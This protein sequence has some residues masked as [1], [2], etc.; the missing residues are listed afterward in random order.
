MIRTARRGGAGQ[1]VPDLGGIGPGGRWVSHRPRGR[2][3]R[4]DADAVASSTREMAE[5][6][7]DCG[8]AAPVPGRGASTGHPRR[9]LSQRRPALPRLAN[10]LKKRNQLSRESAED[11]CRAPKPEQ[12][13]VSCRQLQAN[14]RLLKGL[15]ASMEPSK[16]EALR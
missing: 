14:K 12:A 5:G 8:R 15:L 10:P 6:G 1:A 16:R 4:P 11:R 9:T 13:V 2:A 7:S 3:P